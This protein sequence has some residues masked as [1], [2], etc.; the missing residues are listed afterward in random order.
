MK[1]RC[2]CKNTI[3]NLLCDVKIQPIFNYDKNINKDYI[4]V[5][6]RCKQIKDKGN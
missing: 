6:G 5:S 1:G 4:R 3:Y 2:D